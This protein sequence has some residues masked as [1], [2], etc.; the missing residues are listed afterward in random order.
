[1]NKLFTMVIYGTSIFTGTR[2]TPKN[3][4][5]YK[6]YRKTKKRKFWGVPI[7]FLKKYCPLLVIF[8]RVYANI[9]FNF[10][11]SENNFEWK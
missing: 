10:F 2:P 3:K 6:K 5:K 11:Y 8:F 7:D 1:M 4:K 9:N